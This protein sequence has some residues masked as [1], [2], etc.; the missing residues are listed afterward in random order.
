MD[1][2][3]LAKFGECFFITRH[4]RGLF[5]DHFGLLEP[6]RDFGDKFADSDCDDL[7]QF[8]LPGQSVEPL[9]SG[10]ERVS[11]CS[12]LLAPGHTLVFSSPLSFSKKRGGLDLGYGHFSR[13]IGISFC[14]AF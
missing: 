8:S 14:S 11:V 2:F 12:L 9:A 7:N 3:L 4:E 10:R 5:S 13:L 1:D 6:A